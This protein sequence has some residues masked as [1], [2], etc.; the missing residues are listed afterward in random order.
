VFLIHG[1]DDRLSPAF[2]TEALARYL[3]GKT[4]IHSLITP[5]LSHVEV[6]RL[7]HLREVFELIHFWGRIFEVAAK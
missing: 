3:R 1:A 6:E 4:E 5:L 7:P 2:E